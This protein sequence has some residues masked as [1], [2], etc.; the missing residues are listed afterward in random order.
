MRGGHSARGVFLALI[1]LPLAWLAVATLVVAACRAA[2][3]ADEQLRRMARAKV[4][5]ETR[6]HGNPGQRQGGPPPGGP[7]AP[8]QQSPASYGLAVSQGV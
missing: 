1:L 2:S 8:S 5:P 3:S 7:P 6:R 4:A